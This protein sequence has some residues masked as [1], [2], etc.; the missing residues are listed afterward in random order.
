M[1]NLFFRHETNI[2]TILRIIVR[3]NTINSFES[4]ARCVET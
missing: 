2:K 4:N 3:T 1:W